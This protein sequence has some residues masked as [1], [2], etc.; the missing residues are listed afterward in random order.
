LPAGGVGV[1]VAQGGAGAGEQ[2]SPSP[3][4][5]SRGG[6]I[7]SLAVFPGPTAFPMKS[8]H[9]GSRPISVRP[10]VLRKTE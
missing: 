8:R 1:V 5:I 10:A 7:L 6:W 4:S 3:A 9:F 2:H